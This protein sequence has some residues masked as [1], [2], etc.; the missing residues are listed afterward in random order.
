[1]PKFANSDSLRLDWIDVVSNYS[2][3]P[4]YY[5]R[6]SSTSA[7]SGVSG[8]SLASRAAAG[9]QISETP[10]SMFALSSVASPCDRSRKQTKPF[11]SEAELLSGISPSCTPTCARANNQSFVSDAGAS[12]VLERSARPKTTFY[13]EYSQSFRTWEVSQH[14][15]PHAVL[16]TSQVVIRRSE[17]CKTINDYLVLGLLG[18][19]SFGKV[20]LV[21]SVT[22]GE[23]LAMKIIP[24]PKTKVNEKRRKAIQRE[25]AVMKR[26]AH[27]N[28][29]RLH[30][31][32]GNTKSDKLY[33]VLQYVAGGTI[34][35]KLTN[36]TI[37]PIEEE[38]LRF[39]A[40]Q[41]VSVLKYMQINGVVHRDIKPEN[42]LVDEDDNVYLSD[43]GVSAV[44]TD[45]VVSGVEGTPAFMAPE[46]CRGDA[47]VTGHLVDIWALG[48]SLFQLMYGV[49][50]F[51]AS[52]MMDLSRQIISGRLIFPDED[53]S[54]WLPFVDEFGLPDVEAS[55]E[56][57]EVIRGMLE[58]NPADRW[59][60]RRI[61]NSDW[62]AE[63]ERET[64]IEG[65]LRDESASVVLDVSMKDLDDAI[66]PAEIMYI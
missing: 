59:G 52:N 30:E 53:P 39:Q 42:I 18:R 37:Q 35:K 7:T 22:T 16:E 55:V 58:K 23:T 40:R 54:R 8:T 32:L 51:I 36:N 65:A 41:L 64:P 34:A 24:A 44:C 48:V 3:D 56:F 31:V 1:M 11:N 25:I 14:M 10:H 60:V 15:R 4:D 6:R 2:E 61:L 38:T 13:M 27:P 62:L 47:E 43:F 29:V 12:G 46:V 63:V 5:S 45:E 66:V 20:K 33:L 50:P 17:R 26:L 9:S 21:E 28:M 49:I 19:G 57:K